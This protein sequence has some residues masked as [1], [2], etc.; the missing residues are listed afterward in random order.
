[1]PNLLRVSRASMRSLD[2]QLDQGPHF[3]ANQ[4]PQA[5][6]P[7]VSP[8]TVHSGRMFWLKMNRI[9]PKR[10]ANKFFQSTE[11]LDLTWFD[12][13]HTIYSPRW[14]IIAIHLFQ[15]NITSNYIQ[16]G[17][18]NTSQFMSNAGIQSRGKKW[19]VLYKVRC[20][21]SLDFMSHHRPNL[22]FYL[23]CSR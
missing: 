2:F 8:S 5:V 9:K 3:S 16:I 11:G 12:S 6:R 7:P 21:E 1:M 14:H 20:M 13:V 10:I 23:L 4:R 19:C 22:H 17:Q 15:S 18:F